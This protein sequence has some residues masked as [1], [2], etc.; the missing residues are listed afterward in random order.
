M[1]NPN[2][3]SETSGAA[4]PSWSQRS[5]YHAIA[6]A[7]LAGRT[8]TVADGLTCLTAPDD[9]LLLLLDA[10]FRLRERYFGRDVTLHV[11]RNAKSGICPEDCG[12]CS[13]STRFKSAVP[14]YPMQSVDEIVRGAREAYELRATRYCIVTA[15]RRPTRSDL[16]TVCEAVRRIKSEMP[17]QICASLGLLDER[18]AATLAKAGVDRF[19]HNLETS[20]RYFPEI[21][22]THAWED[23]A[24]TIRRAK[25]AGMEACCGGI[26]GL[27]ETTEDR[28][29][30]ALELHEL[31]V[32]SVP[33]NF[34]DP[35][36]GTPLESASRLTPHEC[37]RALAFFRIVHK[38]KDVRVAGG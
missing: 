1:Q 2:A 12:F 28:V 11:L 19:N 37:L 23:R 35:R 36:P 6:A 32:E 26:I 14:R 34:L 17:I 4:R 21:V 38:D 27:G 30:L 5:P 8:P 16:E 31:G 15:T 10:A 29:S 33:L 9:E 7:S 20:R 22:G 24:E 13:Q 25:A 3:A 18:D